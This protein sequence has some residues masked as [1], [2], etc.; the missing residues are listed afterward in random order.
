MSTPSASPGRCG[1]VDWTA[2]IVKHGPDYVV[3]DKPAGVSVAGTV[4]NMLETCATMAARELGLR[5]PLR[6][7]HQ[8]DTCTEGCVV[9]AKTKVFA[10][11]FN[12]LLQDRRVQKLYKV[13]VAVPVATGCHVHFMRPDRYP[14]RVVSAEPLEGWLRCQLEVMECRAVP[15][16]SMQALQHAGIT[17]SSS[18]AAG[19]QHQAFECVV[20]LVTGRTHQIRAQFAAFGAPL[21]GD[22]LNA[23]PPSPVATLANTAK[24]TAK[25]TTMF[26]DVLSDQVIGSARDDTEAAVE[27]GR[28]G[29][30]ARSQDLNEATVQAASKDGG[31]KRVMEP[32]GAIGLQAWLVSW[33]GEP[34]VFEAGPA[35]WT[36]KL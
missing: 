6:V 15:W 16:P 35:W 24:V 9:M 34:S 2:R 4:D 32:E 27:S 7:T 3:V 23:Q 11:K 17:S 30:S 25:I 33:D 31:L 18:D 22:T 21:V 10:S 14:P 12:I 19:R 5:A 20:R 8:L 13:L 36:R 26:V 1:S 29:V 28:G